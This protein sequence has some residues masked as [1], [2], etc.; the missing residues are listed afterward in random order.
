MKVEKVI[1]LCSESDC[2]GCLACEA[3]CP[4]DAITH[5]KDC[6][7][8]FHPYI[9]FDL[10][11]K[12]GSC[13]KICPVINPVKKFERGD[14]YASWSKNDL[15][16]KNSS[17]GGLFSE[18]ALHILREGGVVAGASM[19]YNRGYVNHV[20]I[21]SEEGLNSLRG[22]KYVQSI[23]DKSLY[24]E[25]KKILCEGK[26]VLFSGCP[27]QVAGIRAYF[28]EEPNLYCIDVACHGVPSPELFSRVY[29]KLK[30]TFPNLVKYNFRSL[31]TWG[32]CTTPNIVTTCS[33]K[34]IPLT[35]K[36]TYYQD[37]FMKGYSLRPNCYYCQYAGIERV[38]D[39]TLADFWGIGNFS[40]INSDYKNGCSL[41]VVNSIKGIRMFD[42]IKQN[43]YWEKRSLEETIYGGNDHFKEPANRPTG[44]D[45]F[46]GDVETL[47]IEDLI[48]KYDFSL[49]TRPSLF[50][51]FCRL[52]RIIHNKSSK[53]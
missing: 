10:C 45:S 21:T 51:R 49:I 26:S 23:I 19:D 52:L 31:E 29:L 7:G 35:G 42:A 6:E 44:R 24:R 37:A 20:I 46:Y 53:K 4:K 25:L 15:I 12:C 9:D 47:P 48:K 5:R 40:P 1:N 34:A 3:I 30:E 11:V 16:R 36:F 14:A 13:V 27:C 18:F 39:I 17:S 32:G 2:S 22:S 43:V 41:V 50:K 33:N 38:G 28:K 8:F